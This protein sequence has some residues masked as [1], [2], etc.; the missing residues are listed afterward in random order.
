M[1]R[2]HCL[3]RKVAQQKVLATIAPNGKNDWIITE[4]KQERIFRE[5]P[6]TKQSCI[7]ASTTSKRF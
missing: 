3:F 2:I 6:T 1:S 5:D 7:R 4:G